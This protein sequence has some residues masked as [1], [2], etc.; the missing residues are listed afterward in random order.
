[1]ETLRLRCV[2]IPLVVAAVAG[3]VARVSAG[4][5]T[6]TFT[7]A[8]APLWNNYSGNWTASGG[9]YYSQAPTNNPTT[10]TALPFDLTDFSVTVDVKAL[11]DGGIWLRSDGTNNNGILLVFGGNGY[12][13]GVRGGNAGTSLYF[14]R[15]VNGGFSGQLA[16]VNQ[17]YTPGQDHTLTVNVTGN[18]FDVLS[19]GLLKTTLVD[20]TYSHGLVGLYDF[21]PSTEPVKQGF[22]N[23]SLS[24]TGVPEPT[25]AAGLLGLT[26]VAARRRR[27]HQ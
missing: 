12:G 16:A 25:S 20:S 19:D 26:A 4:T 13:P 11:C 9:K 27:Q 14:H 22:T 7:P 6:D 10:D 2:L 23:F 17:I 21:G 15:V 8:P 24:G 3:P 5:F 1:M 18:T